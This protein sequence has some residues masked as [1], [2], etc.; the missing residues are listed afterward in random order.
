M[1]TD[2]TDLIMDAAAR[3]AAYLR[4]A[5]HRPVWPTDAAVDALTGFPDALPDHGAPAAE[6]LERLDR[7]GSPATVVSNAGRYLGFVTGGTDPAAQAAAILSGAWDQNGA[8][9]VMS[10][11][12]A[13]LDAVAADWCTRLLGLPETATG[14][15]CGGATIANLTCILAA[16]DALLHRQGWSVDERGMAGAPALRVVTGEVVHV[17]ALKALRAAGL[18]SRDTVLVPT[19]GC[20]RLIADQLPPLD[21]RT[22]VVLQAGNVNTGHSDPF[23]PVIA[24]AREAGAWVHVDGA[25]GLWAAAAPG[26]AGTVAGVDGADSWATDLH[27]WLNVS[28][29][30]GLAVCARGDDLRRALATD[31]AYVAS[32]AE[33]V[34]M[35]L[36]LQMSQRARGI[37]AWAVIAARGRSGVAAMVEECCAHAERLAALLRRGGAEIAAPVVLNQVLAR[38]GDDARTTRVIAAVQREGTTWAG[39]T[40]WKGRPAMRLSVSDQATTGADITACAEAVLACMRRAA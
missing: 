23:G 36:S 4:T 1:T 19:D 26:R 6:V 33:R 35:H 38:F 34:P 15:F 9:P 37:E 39:G 8:M 31:A 21:D 12:A 17:S 5:A 30:S 25:F 18:G 14:A 3:A 22:L 7:L 28:Y 20:G 29:D 32:D 40:V 13:R 16:R 11:V 2:R 27:K 10:P 24:A